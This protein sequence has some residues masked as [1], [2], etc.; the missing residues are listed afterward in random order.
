M[1]GDDKDLAAHFTIIGKRGECLCGAP[2]EEVFGEVPKADYMDSI[3]GDVADARNE[4]EDNTMYITLNLTRVLAFFEE[5]HILSKK[6]G[7]DWGLRN[8]P[9][10]YRF[11]IWRALSEYTAGLQQSYDVELARQFADYMLE[12]IKGKK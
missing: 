1:N 7:G 4:I 9:E 3:W 12:R 5:G 10:L 2:I 8:L 6:E 11:L